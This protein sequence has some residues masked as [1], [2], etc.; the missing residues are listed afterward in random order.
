MSK[1]KTTQ[2]RWRSKM[3]LMPWITISHP[4]LVTILNWCG[5]K[6]VA[7]AS[8]NWKHKMQL[9]SHYNVSLITMGWIP[10]EGLIMAKK[11][12]APRICAIRYGM[13][14]CAIWEQSWNL[15]ENPL[16]KFS[17]WKEFWS[18]LKTIPE[19][20]LVD[21]FNMHW[22]VNLKESNETLRS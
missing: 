10:F 11:H 20:P 18:Y 7:K 19:R 9:V 16:V 21:K 8:Q 1:W 6:C 12:V 14:P 22:N 17:K 2:P 13:W 3:H 4:P 5:E 15:Y